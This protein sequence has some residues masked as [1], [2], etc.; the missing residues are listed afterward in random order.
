M[1]LL[2]R[3]NTSGSRE[4][5]RSGSLRPASSLFQRLA[6]DW[7][8]TRRKRSSSQDEISREES[9]TSNRTMLTN[10]NVD[11]GNTVS[12]RFP[13]RSYSTGKVSE[14]AAGF[15][16]RTSKLRLNKNLSGSSR[17]SPTDNVSAELVTSYLN[18][19]RYPEQLQR[20]VVKRVKKQSRSFSV[21]NWKNLPAKSEVNVKSS[22]VEVAC[23][24][25]SDFSIEQQLALLYDETKYYQDAGSLED[26]ILH[27]LPSKVKTEC[28]YHIYGDILSKS[29]VFF[30]DNASGTCSVKAD[31]R[32]EKNSLLNSVSSVS[33]SGFIKL[34]SRHFR[35][36]HVSTGK[37]LNLSRGLYVVRRGNA[38]VMVKGKCL[39]ELGPGAM[40]EVDVFYPGYLS[41]SGA[42]YLSKMHG[43]ELD[44]V[45]FLSSHLSVFAFSPSESNYT[46]GCEFGK[47]SKDDFDA[48]ISSDRSLSPATMTL[49]RTNL[50]SYCQLIRA[51]VKK[52]REEDRK[53]ADEIRRKIEIQSKKV[54]NQQ[55]AAAC[56]E[57]SL[58]KFQN[59]V[60][61]GASIDHSID[62]EMGRLAIHVSVDLQHIDI[63]EYLLK[64]KPVLVNAVDANGQTPLHICCR[65]HYNQSSR[66][67]VQILAECKADI[68]IRDRFGNSAFHLLAACSDIEMLSFIKSSKLFDFVDDGSK[69]SL[70]TLE[71]EAGQTPLDVCRTRHARRLL[72]PKT[73][74]SGISR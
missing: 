48:V 25:R 46:Y 59:A 57:G 50:K 29:H 56:Y 42:K 1:R 35:R 38:T 28:Y 11:N 60:S 41:I 54:A 39:A 7:E 23:K 64:T 71:N 53:R 33:S 16:K 14:K 51:K 30:I 32:F 44:K 19:L 45:V 8:R 52:R 37:R 66:K 36:E 58:S 3:S 70:L 22:S 63:L 49:I 55:L 69:P 5:N 4:P 67:I 10:V 21:K 43:K 72:K 24:D 68:R 13:Q 6:A 47:L 12:D 74:S 2:R 26:I 15:V 31:P 62:S 65:K 40:I 9:V 27:S 17:D 18:V 20:K 34:I 61:A 73:D